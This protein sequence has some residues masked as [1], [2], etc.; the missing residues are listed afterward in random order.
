MIAVFDTN[1]TVSAIFWHNSAARRCLAGLARRKFKLA[2]TAEIAS[3]YALTCAALRLR[4]PRQD[5]SGPLAWIL[6][7]ADY[8]EPAP[9]GSSAAATQRMIRFWLALWRLARVRLSRTTETSLHWGS[10]LASQLS[11][12]GSFCAFWVRQAN[13]RL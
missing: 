3:D 9:L 8:V 13:R 5:P 6:S 11:P 10:H 7:R 1:V 4:R 12:L 2:A